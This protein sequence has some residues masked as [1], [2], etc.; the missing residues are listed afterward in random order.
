MK[1]VTIEWRH[2]EV[3]GETC[4]RCSDTGE[5]LRQAIEG[6]NTE[7]AAGGVRFALQETRLGAERLADS[8]AVLIDGRPLESLLAGAAVGSSDCPCC[9]ELT[10]TAD[11]VCR[12]LEV[13]GEVHEAISAALIRDAACVV[14]D[15]CGPECGCS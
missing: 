3:E 15:C 13:G 10:D 6:L 12:T 2:L 1:Q 7:C 4:D 11:S 5:E 8:N 9:S 14:A